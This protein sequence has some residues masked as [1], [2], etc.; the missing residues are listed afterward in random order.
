MKI[1]PDCF[2]GTL[3]R[4]LG[5]G[6]KKIM[7]LDITWE[8]LSWAAQSGCNPQNWKLFRHY[9]SCQCQSPG[10]TFS[11]P[12]HKLE[13]GCKAL[14]GLVD[15]GLALSGMSMLLFSMLC[16]LNKGGCAFHIPSSAG[17][18][19][20]CRK[21]GQTMRF[22]SAAAAAWEWWRGNALRTR[23]GLA[24]GQRA[25][26]SCCEVFLVSLLHNKAQHR[27]VLGKGVSAPQRG[28]NQEGSQLEN[29]WRLKEKQSLGSCSWEGTSCLCERWMCCL[30]VKIWSGD[31]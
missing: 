5:R 15:P 13:R 10:L 12:L 25:R 18:Q 21:Q 31:K 14:V 7:A 20:G 23:R 2:S 6:W 22:C 30:L 8:T 11:S 4:L 1:L 3:E 9:Y 16:G 27:A 26:F 19:A 29:W 24:R 28:G 17:E